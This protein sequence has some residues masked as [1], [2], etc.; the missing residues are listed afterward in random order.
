MLRIRYTRPIISDTSGMIS[1]ERHVETSVILYY[2]LVVSTK[3]RGKVSG[4]IYCPGLGSQSATEKTIMR[5]L[6]MRVF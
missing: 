2:S 6:I 4:L 5:G 1:K 3:V